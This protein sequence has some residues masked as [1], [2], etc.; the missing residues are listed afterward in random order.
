MTVNRVLQLLESTVILIAYTLK[1]HAD[2]WIIEIMVSVY[3]FFL[4]LET[5]ICSG[6][7]CI[8]EYSSVFVH[9]QGSM[10]SQDQ[11]RWT[12]YDTEPMC[13]CGEQ[14]QSYRECRS[15][16]KYVNQFWC[17]QNDMSPFK[18]NQCEKC[19]QLDDYAYNENYY[20]GNDDSSDFYD[21]S[22]DYS[23]SSNYGYNVSFIKL[24]DEHIRSR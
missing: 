9:C 6:G 17:S 4:N 3:L 20:I 11:S 7:N 2:Y 18:F 22:S 24:Q 23:T 8:T 15:G 16:D 12:E 1:Y 21:Y 19:Q 10:K 14:Q 5:Y 13:R